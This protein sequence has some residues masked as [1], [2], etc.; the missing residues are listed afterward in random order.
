MWPASGFAIGSRVQ[1]VGQVGKNNRRRVFLLHSRPATVCDSCYSVESPERIIKERENKNGGWTR[2]TIQPRFGRHC[3]GSVSLVFSTLSFGKWLGIPSKL[4]FLTVTLHGVCHP[5]RDH[6]ASLLYSRVFLSLS[7]SGFLV[8]L[9]LLSVAIT[10]PFGLEIDSWYKCCSLWWWRERS[11]WIR[12][13]V[14][15]LGK[16]RDLCH[17][18]YRFCY[19]YFGFC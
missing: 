3:T 13:I 9:A 6:F 15:W 5:C 19:W 11:N 4:T 12:H 2:S 18:I 16:F 14:A 8:K 7:R 1:F 17:F 10:K